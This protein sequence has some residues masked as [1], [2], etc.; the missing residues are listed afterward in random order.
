LAQG[1]AQVTEQKGEGQMDGELLGPGHFPEKTG[2]ELENGHGH[3][4][5]EDDAWSNPSGQLALLPASLLGE[6]RW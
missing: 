2:V 1:V 5:D 4:Y 6:S 3:S